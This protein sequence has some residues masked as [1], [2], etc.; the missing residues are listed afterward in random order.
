MLPAVHI[1][2]LAISNLSFKIQILMCFVEGVRIL[3]LCLVSVR[4]LTS[5]WSCFHMLEKDI[6]HNC[7]SAIGGSWRLDYEDSTCICGFS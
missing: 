6:N 1:G 2:N 4:F 5:L 7:L 3:S